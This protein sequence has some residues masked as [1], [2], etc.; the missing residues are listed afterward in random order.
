MT[1][2]FRTSTLSAPRRTSASRNFVTA[3]NL[4]PDERYIVKT[5]VER[6]KNYYKMQREWARLETSF[7]MLEF[8]ETMSAIDEYLHPPGHVLDLGGGPGR[9]TIQLL[10]RGFSVT[11]ADLSAEL[12]ETAK[13]KILEAKLDRS[14]EGIDCV[15]ATDLSRYPNQHF[16][17]VLALG[18]FYHLLSA[19]ERRAALSEITRVLKPSGLLLAAFQPRISTL[20]HFIERAVERPE[21]VAP[22]SLTR[23]LESG[24][25]RNGGTEGFQEAYFFELPEAKAFFT[26]SGLTEL[27]T[28]SLRGIMATIEPSLAKLREE[29]PII[30]S[31]AIAVHR[32]TRSLEAVIANSYHAVFIGRKTD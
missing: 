20:I 13:E 26:S 32:R 12:L 6:L 9:Y 21:Q 30:Y 29:N 4:Q 10:E 28:R 31:E 23:L 8:Q 27:D 24:C 16:D 18:P 19:D 25:F 5:E 7:G 2:R 15:D 3:K 1:N 11:L 14:A 22:G 17:A